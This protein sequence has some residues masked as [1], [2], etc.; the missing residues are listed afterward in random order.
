MN[1]EQA[2]KLLPIIQAFAEGKTIQIRKYGEER[3][4]D[5]TNSNLNFA[6]DYYE[7]RIKL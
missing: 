1:R 2:K 3:Y 5:S 7:Y 6:L 4:Y